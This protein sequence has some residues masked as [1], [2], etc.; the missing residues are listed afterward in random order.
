MSITLRILSTAFFRV[1]GRTVHHQ[2]PSIPPVAP[3][4]SIASASDLW[5]CAPWAGLYQASTP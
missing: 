2:H 3:A 5:S 4:P 1:P